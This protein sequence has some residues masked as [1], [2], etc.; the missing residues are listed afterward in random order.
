MNRD[1]KKAIEILKGGGI[2]IFPTDTVFGIGCRV[3]NEKAVEKLFKIKG[4]PEKRVAP[5]L[6]DSIEMAQK[7]L[8]PISAEVIE[9]LMKVHWPGSLTIV[10]PCKPK[11]TPARLQENGKTLGVRMPNYKTI[12]RIIKNIGVP[13]IGTSANFYGQ[14]APKKF[15]DIDKRLITLVDFV[16]TGRCEQE[17]PS[18]IIDCSQKPWKILREGVVKINLKFKI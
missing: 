10:L 12:L 7:Y 16:L 15:S 17:V 14:K 3:D 1:I 9:K 2:V 6:V 5:I 4:K 13:I 8:K 18:T 11:K